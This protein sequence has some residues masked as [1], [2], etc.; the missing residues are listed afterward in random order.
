MLYVKL[1]HSHFDCSMEVLN[2]INILVKQ[3]ISEVSLKKVSEPVSYTF[4]TKGTC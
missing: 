1:E 3:W 2:K 4:H